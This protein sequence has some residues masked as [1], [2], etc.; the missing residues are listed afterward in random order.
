MSDGKIEKM[1]KDFTPQVDALLPETES[2]AKVNRS[3]EE[4]KG[5]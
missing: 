2:L 3:K 1:E 4:E 5:G